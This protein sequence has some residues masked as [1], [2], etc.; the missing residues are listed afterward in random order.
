MVPL[1]TT[2]LGRRP[3]DLDLG[4]LLFAQGIGTAPD[5]SDPRFIDNL[6]SP[7]IRAVVETFLEIYSEPSLTWADIETS[8]ERTRLS[9]GAQGVRTRMPHCGRWRAAPL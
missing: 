8:T 6:P 7:M 3:Q 2:M 5:A 9:R 4:S 1:D